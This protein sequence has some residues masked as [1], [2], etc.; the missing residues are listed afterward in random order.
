MKANGGPTDN[1][2]FV[3]RIRGIK[4]RLERL[5]IDGAAYRIEKEPRKRRHGKEDEQEEDSHTVHLLP[6]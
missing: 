6:R 5:R 3:E 2:E 4:E 1:R